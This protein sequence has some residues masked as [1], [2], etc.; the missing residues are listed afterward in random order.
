MIDKTLLRRGV[1]A[2][3][4]AVV[5][6]LAW[7]APLDRL[8]QDYVESGLKRALITFAAARTANAIIS[9]AQ[10]TTVAIQPLGVGVTLSP[11]QV[12]DPINDLVEQFSALM[13]AACISF[14]IQR[15][16]ISIGGYEWVTVFLTAALL[17]WAWVAW[18]GRRA[19]T[20]LVRTLLVLL[21]VRF[22]VP[23]SA[24]GSEA[25]FRLTMASDYAQAESAIDVTS[26]EISRMAPETP[27]GAGAIER[28]KDWW[29]RQKQDIQLYFGQLKDKAE[30]MVRHII[31]LMALFTVQTLLLPLFFLWLVQRLLRAA[32]SWSSAEAISASPVVAA[33]PA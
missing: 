22:A 19:P 31:V 25:A 9:A 14:A 24:M 1:L 16:L 17:G 26:S 20:W 8:A 27:K 33:R 2:A 28:L 13:L 12:L 21:L 6:A 11:A 4:A 7:L 23:I 30:N 5:L 15:V 29:D 3:G 18:Q 32:L 10:E